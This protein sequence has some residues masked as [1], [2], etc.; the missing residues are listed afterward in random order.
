MKCIVTNTQSID[1]I[2]PEMSDFLEN[3]NMLYV[4]REKRS[5]DCLR[6][7]YNADEV[8]VWESNGPVLYIEGEKF[9]FHP[10]MAK[11]R[12]NSFRKFSVPDLMIK[13]CGLERGDDFL[14][15]TLGLGADSVVA[16]YFS[17]NGRVV[18][19]ESES[20]I[21]NIVKWG[22]LHYKGKTEW[23]NQTI[24]QIQVLHYDHRQFLTEQPDA[25]F[26]VVYFDPMF[27]KPLM[28][29]QSI[30]PLRQLAN[31]A[32]LDVSTIEQACRVARKTVVMKERYGSEEFARLGFDRVV[33]SSNK[34]IAYGVIRL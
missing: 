21:A 2:T 24:R 10:S 20:G 31:Y 17:G 34:K 26:D 23:L 4:P 22:M 1:E 14:D 25:S 28:K 13:T 6:E 29:S 19:L 12:I 8:I 3:I 16:A 32:V 9:F 15:C 30:S 7:T 5:L 18:G 27:Q 11:N 33:D